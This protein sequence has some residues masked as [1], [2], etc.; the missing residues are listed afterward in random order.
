MPLLCLLGD[1]EPLD[2]QRQQI[3]NEEGAELF[4]YQGNDVEHFT[5]SSSPSGLYQLELLST[6]KDTHCK[7]YA[8]TTPESDQ[9]YPE[10]PYDPRV[11]VTSLGRTS[12]TLAWKP[13][14]TASVL[15][16]PVQYCVV[17][18]REHNFKSLCAVEARLRADDAFMLAPSPAGTSAPSTSRTSGLLP[19]AQRSS[20]ASCR[21]L[22]P[23]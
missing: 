11:D 18:S 21:S 20:A 16:Q 13:S 8:T 12:V 5:S 9:P 4:S 6:E 2:Q 1:P 10:L 23:G 19:R 14:P 3:I 7:V 22:P 17:V 15:K